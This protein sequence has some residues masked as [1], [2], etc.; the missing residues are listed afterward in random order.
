M[1]ARAQK[2]V[3]RARINPISIFSLSLNMK[4]EKEI[5]P[6]T[7]KEYLKRKF[8]NR[9][10]AP[11]EE[12]YNLACGLQESFINDY[13]VLD[14]MVN[15]HLEWFLEY[16]KNNPPAGGDQFYDTAVVVFALLKSLR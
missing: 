13:Y 16:E 6:D 7:L 2:G 10:R 4:F 3:E 8:P 12:V 14:S 5:N 9:E 11:D 1:L 15:K